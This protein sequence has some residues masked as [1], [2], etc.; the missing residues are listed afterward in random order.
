MRLEVEVEVEVEDGGGVWF[1]VWCLV[2]R[3]SA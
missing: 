2:M 3:D 1:G